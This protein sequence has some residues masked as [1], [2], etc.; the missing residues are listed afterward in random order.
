MLREQTERHAND[1]PNEMLLGT[2]N[3]QI[4]Q[5][6]DAHSAGEASAMD[7]GVCRQTF[8]AWVVFSFTMSIITL[9]GRD[10]L[11]CMEGHFASRRLQVRCAGAEIYLLHLP[12]QQSCHCQQELRP[13]QKV[14]CSS[15]SC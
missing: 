1:E 14:L 6:I 2:L 10:T 8:A 4:S 15:S 3:K 5:P 11:F 9:P 12:H 7:G 13:Q